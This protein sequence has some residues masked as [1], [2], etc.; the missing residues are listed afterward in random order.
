MSY[1]KVNIKPK[2]VIDEVHVII[3]FKNP[4]ILSETDFIHIL[5]I[6]NSYFDF[7]LTLWLFVAKNYDIS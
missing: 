3:I 1:L 2:W 6:F 7:L 5:F 4:T